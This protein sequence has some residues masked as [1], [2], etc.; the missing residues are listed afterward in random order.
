MTV[1]LYLGMFS[2]LENARDL[3]IIGLLLGLYFWIQMIRHCATRPA[4]SMEKFAWLLF[5]I[6][7]PPLGSLLYFFLRVAPT[8]I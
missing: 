7:V 3:E 8:R 6:V 1:A 5:M 2:F 4:P